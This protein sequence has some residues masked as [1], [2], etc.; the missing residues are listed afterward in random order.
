[1]ET[2]AKCASQKPLVPPPRAFEERPDGSI[3]LRLD[4]FLSPSELLDLRANAAR[5][6]RRSLAEFVLDVLLTAADQNSSIEPEFWT[7]GPCAPGWS[8][9]PEGEE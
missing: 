7:G 8:D 9:S 2:I 5:V 6:G 1:M 3:V 4:R